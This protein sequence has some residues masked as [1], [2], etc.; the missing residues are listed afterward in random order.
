MPEDNG[1]AVAATHDGRTR[2]TVIRA[3]MPGLE[4][5]AASD[6]DEDL[7]PGYL[8]LLRIL[9]SPVNA[10]TEIN[11]AWE[12]HFLERF[13]PGAWKKT[14][15]ERADKIRSLFQHGADPQIGDKPLGP[16][17]KL[18]EGEDGGYGEVALLDTSYNRDLLPGLKDGL[19]G[20]SHRFS[21][22]RVEEDDRPERSEH[23]PL[24]LKE[25]T[26]REARLFEFGPV[27]FPAYEGATAGMRS[28]TDEFLISCFRSDPDRL[29]AMFDRATE[30]QTPA[31]ERDISQDTAPSQP[32]A[33]PVGT[34]APERRDSP[35]PASYG[36][37]EKHDRRPSWAL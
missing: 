19:Y 24:G 10:W 4:F 35:N 32:D 6:V 36:L 28:M 2:E 33:A 22:M 12:G 1:A 29:R 17:R 3:G 7:G 13:A 5:R 14:I 31:S 16:I 30:L 15:S 34:S 26:I 21:A 25:R 8:G 11:S 27:T 9:F 23:N 18:V 37:T 20:A